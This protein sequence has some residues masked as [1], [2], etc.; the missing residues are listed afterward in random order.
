M[1][2]LNR[3]GFLKRGCDALAMTA[4]ARSLGMLNFATTASAQSAADYKALVCIFLFGGND[5]NN[6]IVPHEQAEYDAYAAVRTTASGINIARDTLLPIRPPS[7]NKQLGLHPSMTHLHRLWNRGQ[8]AIVSNVGTLVEPMTRAQYLANTALKPA[9]LFSHSDQQGQWQASI[10][11]GLPGTGWGGRMSDVTWPLN[12]GVNFPMSLSV[13]GNNLFA[14]SGVHEMLNVP[15]T[16]TFGL[17]GF[18]SSSAQMARYSAMQ[19]IL[20]QDADKTLVAR[21]AGTIDQAIDYSTIIDPIVNSTTSTIEK[22]FAKQSASISR[23]LLRIAKVIERRETLGLKRQ[24]FFC[25]L[26][27]FDTHNGQATT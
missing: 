7:L 19:T 2:I 10:S 27:G 21:S 6:M 9:A 12:G 18:G 23:Q 15:S 8:L 20:T 26:G 3:R 5:S 4:F 22:M 25:S 17:R 14:T 11:D 16:G 13:A 24:I 1:I